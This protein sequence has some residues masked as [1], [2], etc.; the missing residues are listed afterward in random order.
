VAEGVESQHQL[1]ALR[2]VGCDRV[3]GYLIGEPMSAESTA[4]LLCQARERE[5]APKSLW[6]RVA[7]KSGR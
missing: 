4:A 7:G 2:Q 3:Q 6:A 5:A 1:D